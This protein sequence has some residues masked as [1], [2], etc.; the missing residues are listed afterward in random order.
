LKLSDRNSYHEIPDK[1]EWLIEQKRYSEIGS[2]NFDW[3]NKNLHP[4]SY[5]QRIITIM[6]LNK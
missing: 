1:I 6:E 4:K 2:N 5:I 3:A